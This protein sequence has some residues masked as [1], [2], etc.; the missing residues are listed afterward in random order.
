M[1]RFFVSLFLILNVQSGFADDALNLKWELLFKGVEGTPLTA[2]TPRP[3][4][5]Y[6]VKIQLNADGIEFLATPPADDSSKPKAETLGLKTSHFLEKHKLQ[7]AINAAP[8]SPVLEQEGQSQDVQGLQISRGKRVSDWHKDLPALTITKDNRANIVPANSPLDH[9]F[10][11]V[12]GFQIVLKDGKVLTGK[13]DLHPRTAVGLTA[14][15]KT[16]IWL[17]I[18]GRQKGYSEGVST[19][20]V[21]KWLKNLGCE[22]GINLDGGGTTTLVIE[23]QNGK[24]KIMNRPIHAG[25]PG[26][27]RVSASHLGLFAKTKP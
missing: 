18:D 25:K 9:V 24:S 27:E 3:L 11:A 15:S 4:A 26:N 21:G 16:M 22:T 12:G 10:N 19:A 13:P 1:V 8:Y 20:E 6:A 5:G 17:V 14:D 7:V 2:T 23:D